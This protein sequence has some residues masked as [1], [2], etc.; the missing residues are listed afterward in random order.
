MS[1]R[2][3]QNDTSVVD[4]VNQV[5]D[6]NTHYLC[7]Q[8]ADNILQEIVCKWPGRGSD[9]QFDGN[10]VCICVARLIRTL[11]TV[12]STMFICFSLSCLC[13]SSNQRLYCTPIEVSGA[14]QN[15][16]LILVCPSCV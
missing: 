11:S 16:V 10:R 3:I 6:H 5:G 8:F 13:P 2:H 4:L 12:I 15:N 9:L 7:A 14:N 1:A